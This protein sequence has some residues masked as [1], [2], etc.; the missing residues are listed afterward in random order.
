MCFASRKEERQKL[1]MEQYK[2]IR[3]HVVLLA[4]DRIAN[5][6]LLLGISSVIVGGEGF[7]IK[8][9][10][11]TGNASISLWA[12]ILLGIAASTGAVVTYTWYRWNKSYKESLRIR[13]VI[14]REIEAELPFQPFTRELDLRSESD[15]IPVS[16]II[17]NLAVIFCVFFVLQLPVLAY[18]AWRSIYG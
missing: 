8:D 17:S 2:A 16:D 13:Y 12:S 6:R 4:N 18:L 10:I 15:Y 7:L 14:L 11:A 3:E 9:I 5:N 1:V